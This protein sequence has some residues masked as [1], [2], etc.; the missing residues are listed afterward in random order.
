MWYE[1]WLKIKTY[2]IPEIILLQFYK[3]W[4]VNKY[5]KS[6]YNLKNKKQ[7]FSDNVYTLETP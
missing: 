7:L 3:K 4:K 6:V 2:L 5:R 1:I